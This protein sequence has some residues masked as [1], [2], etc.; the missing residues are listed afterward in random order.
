MG[1]L[2]PLIQPNCAAVKHFIVVVLVALITLTVVFAIYRPD[3]LEGAWL[4][5]VGMIGPII[6]LARGII[7]R[8]NQYFK[9]LNNSEN[10]PNS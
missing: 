9:S 10:N 4:W 5:V 2:F 7:T 1:F 3:L 6:A 8:V